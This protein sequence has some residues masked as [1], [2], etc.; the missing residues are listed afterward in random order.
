MPMISDDNNYQEDEDEKCAKNTPFSVK[1]Q[2]NNS[3]IKNVVDEKEDE[4]IDVNNQ[5]EETEGSEDEDEVVLSQSASNSYNLK[6]RHLK[7]FGERG[8]RAM[9]KEMMQLH[10]MNTYHPVDQETLS[11]EDKEGALASL[12]FLVEKHS[13][14]IKARACANGSM[15]RQ[16]ISKENTA[17]PMVNNDLAF[18]NAAAE[19]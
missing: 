14:E 16:Y 9:T 11:N 3:N 5:I 18:I 4:A 19:A 13:G 1:Q 15:K 17:T 8:E 7:L 6:K 2:I 12:I 10:E